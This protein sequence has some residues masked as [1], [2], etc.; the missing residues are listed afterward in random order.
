MNE[1]EII[2]SVFASVMVATALILRLVITPHRRDRICQTRLTDSEQI[3]AEW[4]AVRV[5]IRR[6]GS[7]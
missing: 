5:L 2:L 7:L 4:S 6:S 1:T 3:N